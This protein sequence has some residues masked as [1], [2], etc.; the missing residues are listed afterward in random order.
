MS[1]KRIRSS[2]QSN[3]AGADNFKRISSISRTIESQL[4]DAGVRTFAKLASLSPE[5]IVELVGELPGITAERIIRQDWIGQARLL[6]SKQAREKSEDESSDPESRGL[7]DREGLTSFVVELLLDE[8]RQVK[9]TKVMQV[10]TGQEDIWDGWQEKRLVDFFV[11][12][13]AM[14]PPPAEAVSTTE[15][16]DDSPEM[17]ARPASPE[18]SVEALP[19]AEAADGL[20]SSPAVAALIGQPRLLALEAVSEQPNLP[21]WQFSS[22]KEFNVRLSLD[23]SEVTITKP[24]PLDY[25]AIIEVKKLGDQRRQIL[26]QS[27]GTITPADNVTLELE[28]KPLSS[29]IYRLGAALTLSSQTTVPAQHND[30]TAYLEGGLLQVY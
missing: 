12:H 26:G 23:L 17:S 1:S 4:H 14:Q 29:G 19:S 20:S 24:G 5:E 8:E 13:A 21:G 28:G 7:A 18:K 2:E 16:M 22:N 10:I 25:I 30:L 6:A 15:V 27:R 9:R 3:P 11:Q